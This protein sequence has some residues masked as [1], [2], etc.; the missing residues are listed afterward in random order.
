MASFGGDRRR[1]PVFGTKFK[2][3]VARYPGRS[4]FSALKP[5]AM[6]CRAAGS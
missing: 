3:S 6:A 5:L 2:G 4:A 1:K